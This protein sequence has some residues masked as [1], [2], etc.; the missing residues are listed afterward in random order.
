MALPKVVSDYHACAG[1]KAVIDYS[2]HLIVSDPTQPVLNEELP[3][4]IAEGYASVKV[5]MTYEA[6]RLSDRQI[7]DVL[8]KS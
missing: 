2:F 5:Y 7:L 1:P 6:M 8:K 3:A 4:L